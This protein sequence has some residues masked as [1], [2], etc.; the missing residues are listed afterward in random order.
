[1]PYGLNMSG[2]FIFQNADLKPGKLA[3]AR[4]N[5]QGWQESNLRMAGSKP[6][7]LPLGDTPV[8]AMPAVA[9]TGNS[10][11][12]H[13]ISSLWKMAGVEGI[14]PTN[15]GIRIRCL[16]AWRHPCINLQPAYSTETVMKN[17]DN[18]AIR[19]IG[20]SFSR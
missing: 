1:M 10:T 19:A 4:K 6:A 16:T 9:G 3:G 5:W 13:R 12:L 20:S 14:E 17:P 15:G 18:I 7:A 11:N 8:T 2:L